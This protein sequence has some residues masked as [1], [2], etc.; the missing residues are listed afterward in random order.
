[1]TVLLLDC[2]HP[3]HTQTHL[4]SRATVDINNGRVL[5]TR[6]GSLGRVEDSMKL[7]TSGSCEGEELVGREVLFSSGCSV[8]SEVNIV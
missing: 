8:Q 7:L 3:H 2:P 4:E 5:G 6:C 1:M